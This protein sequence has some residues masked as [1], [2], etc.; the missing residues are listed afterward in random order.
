VYRQGWDGD[1]QKGEEGCVDEGE[2]KH[3]VS[4]IDEIG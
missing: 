1:A 3:V 2:E 4:Q